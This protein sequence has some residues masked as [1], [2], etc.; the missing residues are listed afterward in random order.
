MAIG[1]GLLKISAA[2]F[3]TPAAKILLPNVP[4]E[5]MTAKAAAVVVSTVN[6]RLIETDGVC[7]DWK[8]VASAPVYCSP[9]VAEPAENTRLA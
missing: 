1:A 5:S 3:C 2:L 8:V 7:V 9:P 6:R 4:E